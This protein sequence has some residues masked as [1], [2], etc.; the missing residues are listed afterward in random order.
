MT[1]VTLQNIDLEN[2]H[3][4]FRERASAL[5]N[6]PE[7]FR[8]ALVTALIAE[9]VEYGVSAES[10]YF[11]LA[12]GD[13]AGRDY[14]EVHLREPMRVGGF[15]HLLSVHLPIERE[16]LESAKIAVALALRAA[17][18]TGERLFL[19]DV[20]GLLA[21]DGPE[22]D[23][24]ALIR[25]RVRARLA[26][27][28]LLSKPEREHLVP[29]SLRDL[30]EHTSAVSVKPRPLTTKSAGRF[31]AEFID[32]E[33]KAGRRPTIDGL[34]AAAKQAGL[35]GG[36]EFLRDAFRR[37]PGVVVKEGRPSKLAE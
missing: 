24:H 22:Y 14:W 18:A 29:G 30:V 13:P 36:R 33:K 12:Y 9:S 2:L 37:A 3:A 10:E 32:R 11:E 8:P 21:F 25:I 27:E 31:V 26:V 17:A 16:R 1:A 19:G 4:L 28:W 6:Q 15:A 7:I 20:A 5:R 35:R 34:E 23:F